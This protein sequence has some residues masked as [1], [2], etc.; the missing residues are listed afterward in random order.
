MKNVVKKSSR[1]L[2][3]V[4]FVIAV[5]PAFVHPAKAHDDDGGRGRGHDRGWH[6]ERHER[7]WH[8]HEWRMRHWHEAVVVPPPGV[9]YTPPAVVYAPPPPPPGINLIV[10]LNFR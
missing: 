2:A 1:V 10:P 8:D 4:A 5:G 7:E 9:V 3:A 6:G